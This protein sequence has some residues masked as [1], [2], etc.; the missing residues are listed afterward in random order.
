MLFNSLREWRTSTARAEGVPPYV[1]FTNRELLEIV[2]LRPDSRTALGHVPGVGPGKIE[3][4]GHAILGLLGA[5]GPR[6]DSASAPPRQD[7][8]PADVPVI[9][10]TQP[11][12]SPVGTAAEQGA[13]VP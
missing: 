6:A 2:R 13:R 7:A 8:T 4:Y 3:R 12:A 11:E 1:L 9:P 10:T 5:R